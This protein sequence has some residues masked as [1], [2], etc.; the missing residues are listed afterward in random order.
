MLDTIPEFREW[1]ESIAE[2]VEV[3]FD[4]IPEYQELI[5]LIPGAELVLG[6]FNIAE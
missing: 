3:I 6:M 4:P 1:V 5:E 2:S